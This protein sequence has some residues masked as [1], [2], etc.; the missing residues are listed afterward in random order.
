MIEI[1]LKIEEEESLKMEVDDIEKVNIGMPGKSAYE[2]AT[3]TQAG[4]LSSDDKKSLD[5]EFFRMLPK[6]GTA[7]RTEGTDIN[8]IEFTKVGN[9]Y[10]SLDL[11]A[12]TFKNTP[13][14]RSFMMFVL[15]PLN[16]VYDNEETTQWCYRIRIMVTYTGEFFV[17]SCSSGS[18]AGKFDFGK[19]KKFIL[20]EV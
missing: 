1:P 12:S 17:Q 10:C 2:I 19:W 4:L 18:E 8:S 15:S 3:Q 16:P 11:T 9:Y 6:G 5:R 7:I 14:T 13:T 20:E